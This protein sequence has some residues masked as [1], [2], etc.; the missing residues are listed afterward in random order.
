MWCDI[1]AELMFL[2]ALRAR[3]SCNSHL[4]AVCL[5]QSLAHALRAACKRSFTCIYAAVLCWFIYDVCKIASALCCIEIGEP[6]SVPFCERMR[7]CLFNVRCKCHSSACRCLEPAYSAATG[8]CLRPVCCLFETRQ[9]SRPRQCTCNGQAVVRRFR[10][11]ACWHI[12][13]LYAWRHTPRPA[14]EFVPHA[15]DV[16]QVPA[17]QV[18]FVYNPFRCH[19][20]LTAQFSKHLKKHGRAALRK[21]VAVYPAEI[22]RFHED[23]QMVS[24]EMLRSQCI[25]GAKELQAIRK[26]LFRVLM[27]KHLTFIAEPITDTSGAVRVRVRSCAACDSGFVVRHACFQLGWSCVV[28]KLA[29]RPVF[30]PHMPY[31]ARDCPGQMRAGAA[32]MA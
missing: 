27:W 32:A 19:W 22:A 5:S 18:I 29:Q 26:T 30:L 1:Y 2:A 6:L 8:I 13:R 21:P 23:G 24:V 17:N 16:V 28:T 12:L 15:C 14:S 3:N 4:I 25:S 7:A 20:D 9:A 31:M 11:N 10:Q